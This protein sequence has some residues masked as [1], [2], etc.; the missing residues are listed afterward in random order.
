MKCLFS[1]CRC[2][3]RSLP[4]KKWF[5][6]VN[7]LISFL[8]RS[9][10]KVDHFMLLFTF[11]PLEWNSYP[12]AH[13]PL[14]ETPELFKEL[15]ITMLCVYIYICCNIPRLQGVQYYHDLP[16]VMYRIHCHKNSRFSSLQPP[17]SSTISLK[18]VATFERISLKF[19]QLFR[20]NNSLNLC[21]IL[22]Y[23]LSPPSINTSSHLLSTGLPRNGLSRASPR[24]WP[25][26]R[27][28][29]RLVPVFGPKIH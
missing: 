19:P 16:A 12:P 28:T 21:C 5:A 9:V 15:A 25:G 13:V 26:G 6:S 4:T 29:P 20:A 1:Q 2:L 14:E 24:G 7:Y 18:M 27:K 11:S 3:A 10:L 17:I 22:A 23:H 8:E